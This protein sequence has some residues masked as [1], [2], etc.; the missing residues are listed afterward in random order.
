M[1]EKGILQYVLK[2]PASS[3]DLNPIENVWAALKSY[4]QNKVKPKTK[5]ELVQGIKTF[6]DSL[7]VE[8]C[9][10]YIDHIHKVLPHVLLNSGGP[11]KF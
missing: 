8:K 6:W 2:T 11:T 4:L 9:K 10:R 1:K 7:S 3:P 5:D